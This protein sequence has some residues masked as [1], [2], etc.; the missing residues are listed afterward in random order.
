MFLWRL[1][2]NRLCTFYTN[3]SNGPISLFSI[4]FNNSQ[5]HETH[6]CVSMWWL[7]HVTPSSGTLMQHVFIGTIY[8]HVTCTCIHNNGILTFMQCCLY[9]GQKLPTSVRCKPGFDKKQ[10]LFLFFCPAARHKLQRP[11]FTTGSSPWCW[12]RDTSSNCLNLTKSSVE[13]LVVNLSRL[14][15]LCDQEQTPSVRFLQIPDEIDIAKN[16]EWGESGN[17]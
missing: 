3:G 2:K 17:I 15:R 9:N 16:H 4:H 14:P 11:F 7:A 13:S 1:T 5:Q 6:I 8:V 10:M 12:S